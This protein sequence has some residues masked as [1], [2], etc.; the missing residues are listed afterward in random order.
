MR[1]K[2]T[3]GVSIL[4]IAS[5]ILCVYWEEKNDVAIEGN[6]EDLSYYEIVKE[7]GSCLE[8]CFLEY[9]VMSD[10][11]IMEK[12]I[13]DFDNKEE[14]GINMLKSDKGAVGRMIRKIKIYLQKY[15][16]N[17]GVDCEKCNT[18]HLYYGGKEVAGS[19]SVKEED[20][21]AEIAEIFSST[22]ILA[23]QSAFS[24]TQF[25]HFYYA[26]KNGAYLDYHIFSNG[27]VIMEEFGN[28][29]GEL[30]KSRIYRL[31][32]ERIRDLQKLVT[33]DFFVEKNENMICPEK[34]FI[35]GYLEIKTKENY[36]YIYTCAN[37]NKDSDIIFNY[38]YNNYK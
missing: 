37:G 16:S 25:V 28:K 2:L 7:N 8:N 15:G 13:K 3:I 24:D 38:L 21:N 29:N 20:S 23:R 34:E 12:H 19:F 4:I 17:N 9:I 32:P 11:E 10:G 22:E 27:A 31:A 36:N 26:K 30:S 18:Y 35:W 14:N 5:L 6:T 33:E 1:I